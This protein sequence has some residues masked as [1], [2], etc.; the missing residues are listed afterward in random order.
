MLRSAEPIIRGIIRDMLMPVSTVD[1]IPPSIQG[2]P[3][4]IVGLLRTSHQ[5]LPIAKLSIET[6]FRQRTQLVQSALMRNWVDKP[7]LFQAHFWPVVMSGY[8]MIGVGHAEHGK[9]LAYLLP[10]MVQCDQRDGVASGPIAVI[11][12][13]D[14]ERID[15]IHSALKNFAFGSV[16]DAIRLYDDNDATLSNTVRNIS[17]TEN[18]FLIAHPKA[19]DRCVR[20][21]KLMKLNEVTFVGIDEADI[22]LFTKSRSLDA[23]VQQLLSCMSRE[24]RQLVFTAAKWCKELSSYWIETVMNPVRSALVWPTNI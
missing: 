24:D 5:F 18:K 7:L 17:W 16:R 20:E 3:Y 13:H 10:A 1:V 19:L 22:L 14:S 8:D 9:L 23:V 11:F 2:A 6:C 4:D 15:A 21:L 12:T